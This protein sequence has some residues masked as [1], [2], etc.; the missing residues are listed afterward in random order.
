MISLSSQNLSDITNIA[1]QANEASCMEDFREQTVSL[2]HKAFKS[3]STIFWLTNEENVMI[4]PVMKDIQNQFL[5]PYKSFFFKQNPFD[6]GNLSILKKPSVIMEE[7]IDLSDFHKTEYY[8]DFL[9]PQNINRQ[10]AIY[11]HQGNKLKGVLGMHRSIKKSFGKKF[12]FM[13]DMI[14]G[15]LTA[16]FEKLSLMEEINKTRDFFKMIN[17]NNSLGIIILDENKE[18]I[19][20]NIKADQISSRLIGK[21]SP[22]DSRKDQKKIVPGIF[23]DYCQQGLPSPIFKERILSIGSNESYRIKYQSIDKKTSGNNKGLLMITLEEAPHFLHI[24]ATLLKKRFDLTKREIE[25]ISY[26]H[27]GFTNLEIAN[28]LFISEGTVKNHLKH[29]F[30]KTCVKNRTSLIHKVTFIKE[31]FF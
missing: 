8:N 27:K 17:E 12:L 31:D 29:I 25:I 24:N 3:T 4:D 1:M 14:A 2:V 9:K 21:Y 18:C 22:A 10:M 28:T 7:L 23:L 11:I 15:H 16:A 6:P 19:F 13:G 5:H 30:A 20:S 26:I